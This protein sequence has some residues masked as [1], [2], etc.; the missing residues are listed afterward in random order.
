MTNPSRFQVRGNNRKFRFSFKR[1]KVVESNFQIITREKFQELYQEIKKHK[2]FFDSENREFVKVKPKNLSIK[3]G[4]NDLFFE[5][6]GFSDKNYSFNA[7]DLISSG[8]LKS[9][10]DFPFSFNY[11][12]FFTMTNRIDVFSNISKIQRNETT[13]DNLKGF[14]SNHLGNSKSAFGQNIKIINNYQKQSD[15][16]GH[17]EDNILSE[18]LTVNKEKIVIDKIIRLVNPITRSVTNSVITK[19][20]NIV[21]ADVR[22]FSNKKVNI[23]PFR[24]KTHDKNENSLSDKQN[25]YVFTNEIINNKILENRNINNAIN[26]FKIY[27]SQGK[28]YDLSTCNG[29]GSILYAEILD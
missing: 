20:K 9:I 6:N 15:T 21:S 26:E 4:I 14:S 1:E 29:Q 17:Y 27:A 16:I 5:E 22:Y 2:P 10:V 8:N 11:D 24:D 18:F 19:K 25:K 23:E 3:I 12:N 13:I 7:K 28:S